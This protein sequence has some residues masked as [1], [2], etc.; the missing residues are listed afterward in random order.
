MPV[1]VLVKFAPLFE[2]VDLSSLKVV[3]VKFIQIDITD[4][5]RPFVTA[6]GI[7]VKEAKIPP[8]KHRVR[9]SLADKTGAVSV[10]EIAFEVL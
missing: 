2:P 7:S 4:R 6:E 10:R 9:I 5:I 3:L 1:H 8:G